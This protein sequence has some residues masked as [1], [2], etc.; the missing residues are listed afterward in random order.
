MTD[1]IQPVHVVLVTGPSG[2]GRTTAIN[3]L[4]DAGF[5]SIDNMP[6]SLAPRLFETPGLSRPI[7]LGLDTRNRDFS[8]AQ[9]MDTI[10][11]LSANPSYNA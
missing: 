9:M 4:E 11:T 1:T 2:A 10:A 8:T 7:A 6:L 5:E 3:A